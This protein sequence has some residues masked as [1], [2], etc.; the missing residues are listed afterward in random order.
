MTFTRGFLVLAGDLL[1]ATD[2]A[3]SFEGSGE[4]FVHDA[5][6]FAVGEETSWHHQHVGIVVLTCQMSYL[7]APAKGCT[8][9]LMLV[10]CHAD[11]FAAATYG[12]A[13]GHF[14]CIDGLAQSVTEVGIVTTLLAVGAIVNIFNAVCSEILLDVL[15]ERK[16][17]VVAGQSY[18]CHWNDVQCLM[19][20]SLGWMLMPQ[21]GLSQHL[22]H[23]IIDVLGGE[24][25]L[26]V[27]HLVGCREAEALESPYAAGRIGTDEEA[28]QID[29]QTSCE[30]EY[31]ASGR[32]DALLV[33]Q[34][35]FA[36]EAFRGYTHHAGTLT[37]RVFTP[38]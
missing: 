22:L 25:Q 7:W 5:V 14:A 18:L 26:L 24:A 20:L 4:E 15:L 29:G 13:C 37:T 38:S 6:G 33:V 17:C 12:N 32:D 36:E 16:A 9:V 19:L 10:E 2:V 8:H 21:G 35:L 30:T 1:N 27:E 34:G 3:A 11:A 23:L 31:L 28:A